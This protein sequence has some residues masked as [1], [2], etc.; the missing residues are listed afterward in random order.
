M[1]LTKSEEWII[2][3]LKGKDYVSPS[4]IGTEHARTFGFPEH[5]IVVGLPLSV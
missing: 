4:V 3:Y 2:S 5:T 1:K